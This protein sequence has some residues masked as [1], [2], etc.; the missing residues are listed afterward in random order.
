MSKI[1]I[2]E[3]KGCYLEPIGKLELINNGI[4]DSCYTFHPIFTLID[5]GKYKLISIRVAKKHENKI[6]GKE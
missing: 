2:H 4:F 6:K 1:I 5:G 3:D